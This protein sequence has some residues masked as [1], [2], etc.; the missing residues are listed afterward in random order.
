MPLISL[1]AIDSYARLM[2]EM[3]VR[4]TKDLPAFKKAIK[5]GKS[6]KQ[7]KLAAGYSKHVAKMGSYQ[8]PKPFKSAWIREK[9]KYIDLALSHSADDQ[10]NIARGSLLTNVYEGKD[11]AVQ[12]IKLLMQDKRVNMLTSDTQVGLIVIQPPASLM[13]EL[14][15]RLGSEPPMLQAVTITT[16]S[17]TP[18]DPD[19]SP[20]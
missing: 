16:D 13:N 11:R 14:S 2:T 17:D 5:N 9:K 3:P 12:S 19:P 15:K 20:L 10:E 18:S 7:A 1:S 8:L 6:L 4:H